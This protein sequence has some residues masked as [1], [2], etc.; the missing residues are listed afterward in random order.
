MPRRPPYQAHP[1]TETTRPVK[2]TYHE[3]VPYVTP[4]QLRKQYG[5]SKAQVQEVLAAAGAHIRQSCDPDYPR[6]AWEDC[7]AFFSGLTPDLPLDAEPLE[8]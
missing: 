8:K 5:L 3:N 6:Y 2:F 4:K 7:L 1:P